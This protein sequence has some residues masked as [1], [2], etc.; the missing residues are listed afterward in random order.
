[1]P[2]P[3]PSQASTDADAAALAGTDPIGELTPDE[4]GEPGV[5]VEI[6]PSEPEPVRVPARAATREPT[7]L[8]DEQV[9]ALLRKDRGPEKA[10]RGAS[11]IVAIIIAA[12]LSMGVVA[13]VAILL[14]MQGV[15]ARSPAAGGSAPNAPAAKTGK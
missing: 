1:M 3:A 2:E 13:A 5:P 12:I 8:S 15:A 14:V 6:E 10:R 11:W 4:P 9:E 7:D